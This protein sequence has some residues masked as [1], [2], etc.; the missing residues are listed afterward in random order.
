MSSLNLA[1]QLITIYAGI[2]IFI[3]G[4]LG[5]ALN[6]IVFLSL[7]TFR[8]SSC[9]FYL[10]VMSFMSV[11]QLTTGLLTRIM[12]TGFNIDWTQTSMF[13][14]KIRLFI[15]YTASLISA[16]CL[17][18]ATI[19]QYLATCIHPR[20]QQWC[21]IKIARGLITIFSILCLVE[22]I[23]SL[24]FYNQIIS[25]TTNQ[26]ICTITNN[27]YVE[28]NS[29]LT[30][31]VLW[32]VLPVLITVMFGML[33][34]RNVQQIAYRTV[35]LVRRELDKQLTVMVLVQVIF[36]FIAVMPNF[37]I[38]ILN[39]NEALKTNL[40]LEIQ[41]SFAA[42]IVNCVFYLYFSVSMTFF[43]SDFS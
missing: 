4:I 35:P 8:Q 34:Y 42:T 5:G 40:Y 22:Q 25:P 17:C 12:I 24:V 6:I 18:L 27:N 41:L 21:N 29:Y 36:N 26:T 39:I 20:W 38:Y 1:G 28:Y 15:L 7:K 31:I 11:G 16:S 19:D 13:Y 9:A 30:I 33:A 14:C 2:P 10:T 3:A 37:I 43:N 23:P 32:Y